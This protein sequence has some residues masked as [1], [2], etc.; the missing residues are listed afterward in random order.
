MP[1]AAALRK[2]LEETAE[3]L[4][5]PLAGEVKVSI[6]DIPTGLAASV[7]GDRP[8]WAASVIKLPVLVAAAREIEEGRMSLGETLLVDHRF[9]LDPMD[10][11]SRLPAGTRLPV[12]DLLDHMICASDNE[13]TNILADRI[14]IGR[15]NEV[16]WGLGLA[17]T[18]LGHLLCR[19]V[20]RHAS[21]FNPDGSN[22]VTIQAYALSPVTSPFE[23][24]YAMTPGRTRMN[25]GRILRNP[26]KMAPLR[27]WSRSLALKTR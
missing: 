10:A 8:G 14:G 21:A 4:E 27:A 6:H 17:R 19:G 25:T 16:A 24:L 20:P 22:V 11:V 23:R 3:R 7:K 26:A 9:V 15:V 13:A 1:V 18:M 2:D 12:R 5:G